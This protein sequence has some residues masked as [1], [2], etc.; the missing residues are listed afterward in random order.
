V[1]L[2]ATWTDRVEVDQP[3]RLSY[4]VLVELAAVMVAVAGRER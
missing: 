2:P 3:T 4:E 1:W